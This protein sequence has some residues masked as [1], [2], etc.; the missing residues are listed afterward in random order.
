MPK[1]ISQDA[2]AAAERKRPGIEEI[3]EGYGLTFTDTEIDLL[4]YPDDLLDPIERQHRYLLRIGL[5]PIQ[6][7][8]CHGLICQRSAALTA[9]DPDEPTPVSPQHSKSTD[10]NYECNRCGAALTSYV[11]LFGGGTGFDLTEPVNKTPGAQ[12]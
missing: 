10:G 6:C 11:L 9:R 4:T 12:E 5:Q 2:E 1:Y 8:A 3:A 7:P